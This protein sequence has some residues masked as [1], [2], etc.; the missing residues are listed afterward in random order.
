MSEWRE[1]HRSLPFPYPGGRFPLDLGA[2]IQRTVLTGDEPARVVVHDADGDWAIGDGVNDPNLP[3]AVVATHIHHI[4][5]RDPSVGELASMPPGWKAERDEP[6]EK[7][8][9]SWHHYDS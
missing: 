4:V 2:A 1:M 8:R 6:G 5:E 7:W 9:R 3:G